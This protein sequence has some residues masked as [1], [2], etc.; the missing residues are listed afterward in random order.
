MSHTGSNFD[1]TVLSFNLMKWDTIYLTMGGFEVIR[2]VTRTT[3]YRKIMLLLSFFTV[4]IALSYLVGVEL[5]SL[6]T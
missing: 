5:I 1:L 2:V 3:S 4:S 6:Y